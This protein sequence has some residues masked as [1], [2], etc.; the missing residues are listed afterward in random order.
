MASM[1]CKV[2]QMQKRS[3]KLFLLIYTW[4]DRARR[5][6]SEYLLFIVFWSSF[7]SEILKILKK[8]VKSQQMII[9]LKTSNFTPLHSLH[10]FKTT[11][12]GFGIWKWVLPC[13]FKWFSTSFNIVIIFHEI[14]ED[15]KITYWH[16]SLA[17]LSSL[18]F[19]NFSS[20]FIHQ[21]NRH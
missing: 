19:E 2:H 11:L 8:G 10:F 9:F 15:E 14:N 20:I 16:P 7:G 5:A 13:K 17:N 3:K 18:L 12:F 4:L 1:L 21:S 6:D